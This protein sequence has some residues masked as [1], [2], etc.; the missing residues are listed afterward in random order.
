[1]PFKTCTDV[2][3]LLMTGTRRKALIGV[4]EGQDVGLI[5]YTG[6]SVQFGMKITEEELEQ[7]KDATG[8][9]CYYKVVKHLLPRFN[10]ETYFEFLAA[11][12][13]NYMTHSMRLKGTHQ[14]GTT[15]RTTT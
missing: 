6:E 3:T 2:S 1:M 13:R 8:D 9:I 4:I 10:G 12:M 14:S 11:R 7:L 15:R 5:S